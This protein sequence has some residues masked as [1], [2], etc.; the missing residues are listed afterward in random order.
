MSS[1]LKEVPKKLKIFNF[2]GNFSY[3]VPV[4][5]L[6]YRG[7]K[8]CASVRDKMCLLQSPEFVYIT[9]LRVC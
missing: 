7:I 4:L 6:S 8:K 2:F 1:V 5:K 9:D 3:A